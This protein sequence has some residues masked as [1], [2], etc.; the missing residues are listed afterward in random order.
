MT[1]FIEDYVRPC[2]Q[3][4]KNY[5]PL[6]YKHLERDKFEE[7]LDLMLEAYPEHELTRWLMRGFCMND[8]DGTISFCSLE[9]RKVLQWDID[10]FDE[11]DEEY[12]E[13]WYG[14]SEEDEWGDD[15]DDEETDT[16][17]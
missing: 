2:W 16:E 12:F 10:H 4:H 9:G 5:P 1:E 3:E 17:A 11:E 15:W 7:L 6:E 13:Q 14:D 8:G